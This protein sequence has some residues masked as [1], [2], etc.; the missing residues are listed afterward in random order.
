[1][2]RNSTFGS[3]TTAGAVLVVSQ[4]SVTIDSSTCSNN[5]MDKWD[6]QGPGVIQLHDDVAAVI[7]RSNFSDN[8]AGAGA[9]IAMYGTAQ[10]CPALR[11][12]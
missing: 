6:E 1:M 4:A 2:V 7:T 8:T 3:L 11:P 12:L 9:G 10:V 5:A